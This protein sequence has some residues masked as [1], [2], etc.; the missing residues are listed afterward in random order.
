MLTIFILLCIGLTLAIGFWASS[1][2]KTS[3][4]FMLAGKSL[5]TPFVGVTLFAIWFGSN[6]I[7]GNPEY[8][9]SNGFS[10]FFSLVISGG[11]VLLTVGV[12]YARRMYRLNIVTVGDFFKTRLVNYDI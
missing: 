12:F 1:K 5:S 2:I 3:Q 7:M 4:D 9:V 10:S 11:I 8:F 6:H